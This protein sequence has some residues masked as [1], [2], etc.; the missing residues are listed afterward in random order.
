MLC[1]PL[2]NYAL[3]NEYVL[4]NV[5]VTSITIAG[6]LG[7]QYLDIRIVVIDNYDNGTTNSQ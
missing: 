6:S 3:N 1:P 4:N 7:T 2:Q 5:I